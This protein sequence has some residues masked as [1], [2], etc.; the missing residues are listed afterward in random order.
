MSIRN[1]HRSLQIHLVGLESVKQQTTTVAVAIIEFN[2]NT[3]YNEL[4]DSVRTETYL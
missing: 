3:E 1:D 2:I 4:Q